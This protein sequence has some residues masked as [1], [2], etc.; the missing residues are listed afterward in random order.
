M[1]SAS[2]EEG[3]VR[4][5]GQVGRRGE[6]P[7]DD[8]PGFGSPAEARDNGEE[9]GVGDGVPVG[10]GAKGLE[11][12]REPRG[13]HPG[14]PLRQT[15]GQVEAVQTPPG[16]RLTAHWRIVQHPGLAATCVRLAGRRPT[17]TWARRWKQ[18][19]P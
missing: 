19:R 7:R 1:E 13:T 12:F 16:N 18:P 9:E 5:D 14:A 15:A 10:Q 8:A 6:A 3:E 4:R 17:W 2:D 11:Q